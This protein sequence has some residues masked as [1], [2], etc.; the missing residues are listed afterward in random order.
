MCSRP[1]ISQNFFFKNTFF[2][3][4]IL[5]SAYSVFITLKRKQAMEQQ[6]HRACE[7]TKSFKKSHVKFKL[8]TRSTV[9][10]SPQTMQFKQ[11]SLIKKIKIGR[12]EHS[13]TSHP[14]TSNN[15]SFLP[16]T[17]SSAPPLKWTSYV[18][19]PLV[20]PFPT[21]RMRTRV[22]SVMNFLR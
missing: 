15:I 6:P 19:H 8:T 14:T 17:P 20:F 16:C 4:L 10:F 9:R 2:S 21:V 11:L 7:K 1:N 18:H 5:Q 3:I 13:L 12:P 22:E